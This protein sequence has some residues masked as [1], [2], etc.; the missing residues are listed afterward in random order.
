MTRKPPRIRSRR[1]HLIG[2]LLLLAVGLP[3]GCSRE[4]LHP[5][6]LT[7]T[8]PI[9]R[10]LLLQNQTTV[11]LTAD[12]PPSIRLLAD[13]TVRRVDVP[14]GA[15]VPLS[16][17]AAGWQFGNA[18]IA[19]G[20]LVLIPAAEGTV[21]V[22][23]VAYRGRYLFIPKANNTFDV[24]NEVDIEGYLKSVVAK[25]MLRQW[26]QIEAF[27]AQ[28]VVARTYAI[29]KIKNA[30]TASKFD[31]YSDEKDQ[32]YGGIAAETP[33]SREAV[34]ATY[35]VVVAAGRDGDEKI[36]KAYFSSCCG[37]IS[38]SAADAFGDPPSPQLEAQN[39]GSLCSA[40]PYF[41]WGPITISKTD[42]TARF[43]HFIKAHDRPEKEIGTIARIDV[44]A[45][46]VFGRPV[47]F[48]VTDAAGHKSVWGD[49]DFRRA[50]N[51]DSTPATK[52]PSSFCEPAVSASAVTFTGHGL[53]HGVGLCQ[54]CTEARA[55]M[56]MTYETIVKLSYPQSK[57]FAVYL[58]PP[59]S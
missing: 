47:R 11:N 23:K 15:V 30:G 10:V 50:V 36:F 33:L 43:R 42:L 22:D 3:W 59:A 9:A 55:D 27:K 39:V 7:G 8:V 28:A 21:A 40:S 45:R 41:N 2:C 12:Q 48:A 16:L 13:H 54:Y 31:L 19:P 46:N 24:V 4:V 26:K 20:E 29:W 37:G 32:V 57:L 1:A 5:A 38:Q 52:L 18:K 14:P 6:D 49:E 56:G 34:D 51:T 17:T 25:E 44:A 53:G 35:G 58:R